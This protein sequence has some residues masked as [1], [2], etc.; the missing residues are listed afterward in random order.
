MVNKSKSR[1]V[2]KQEDDS[3]RKKMEKEKQRLREVHDVKESERMEFEK[4]TKENID[5]KGKIK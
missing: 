2:E 1:K 3:T 5:G 4:T